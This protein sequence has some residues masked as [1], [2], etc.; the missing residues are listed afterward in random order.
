MF[1]SMKRG[2]E[3]KR[4]ERRGKWREDPCPV[5]RGIQCPRSTGLPAQVHSTPNPQ[6]G[7][8]GGLWRPWLHQN[9]SPPVIPRAQGSASFGFQGHGSGVGVKEA[10]GL[11]GCQGLLQGRGQLE[12]LNPSPLLGSANKVVPIR[13][14]GWVEPTF[15]CQPQELTLMLHTK[16]ST[17][18]QN[19]SS[20]Q[21]LPTNKARATHCPSC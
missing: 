20:P 19:F 4:G 18:S 15:S 3:E 14:I 17:E 12:H 9:V 1:S 21:K 8:P 7:P 16:A 5:G 10:A 6:G 2:E 13:L 11:A